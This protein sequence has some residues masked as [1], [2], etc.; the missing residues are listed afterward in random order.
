MGKGFRLFVRVAVTL[1]CAPCAA[2]PPEAAKKITTVRIRS[3]DSCVYLLSRIANRYK[4]DHPEIDVQFRGGGPIIAATDLAHGKADL[5]VLSG[6]KDIRQHLYLKGRK[7]SLLKDVFKEGEVQTHT[8]ARRVMAVVVHPKSP[9]NEISDAT[10][11]GIL[12]SFRSTR[13]PNPLKRQGI[14]YLRDRLGCT[15]EMGRCILGEQRISLSRFPSLHPPQ[16]VYDRVK[17][18]QKLMAFVAAGNRLWAS[19]LKILPVRVQET[20]SLVKLNLQNVLSGKYPYQLWLL[21]AIHPDATPQA[22]QV[23]KELLTREVA[24]SL[25]SVWVTKTA[26]IGPSPAVETVWPAIDPKALPVK[27]RGGVAVLPTRPLSHYFLMSGPAVHAAYEDKVCQGI[28][29]DG[30][31]KLVDRSELAR[32]LAERKLSLLGKDPLPRK[33]L[34]AA[35]VTVLANVITD[36]AA[37]YLRISAFH[38]PTASCIGMMRLPIDPARPEEFPVPLAKKVAQWWPGVLRNL[39]AAGSKPVWT[40]SD[41]SVVTGRADAD[42]DKSC[43]ALQEALAAHKTI[44]FADPA[45]I[46][47]AQ[48]EVLMR[49]MGLAR[50]L[51]ARFTP[52]ADYLLEFQQ[53]TPEEIH[54][55]LLRG[56]DR[57]LLAEKTFREKSSS[58]ALSRAKAWLDSQVAAYPAKPRTAAG[59][60]A[61]VSLAAAK[62]QARVEC[63]RAM[64][65]K[66]QRTELER[67]ID[68][69]PE[70]KPTPEQAARLQRLKRQM[71]RHLTVAC[72]Q[73][74][75]WVEPARELLRCLPMADAGP[76]PRFRENAEMSAQFIHRFPKHKDIDA[77][78]ARVF[79]W[80]AELGRFVE[81]EH[82]RRLPGMGIPSGI[83]HKMEQKRC[84]RLA[85]AWGKEYISRNIDHPDRRSNDL[86]WPFSMFLKIH[87]GRLMWYLRLDNVSEAEAREVVAEWAQAVDGHPEVVEHS[88]FLRLRCYVKKGKKQA[89]LKLLT[90]MQKRWPDPKDAQWK[91]AKEQVLNDL[92]EMFQVD[93]PG[94]SFYQ[95][96]HGK[97]GIG[98]LP[99]VGYK[100]PKESRKE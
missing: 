95:W 64:V 24:E 13:N 74:P 82:L 9:F 73:D 98:D 67:T 72:Q 41:T 51:G 61:E 69:Q 49:M 81:D 53:D 16:R 60:V 57:K 79:F 5:A 78:M 11:R 85:L 52:A 90:A 27:V 68:G 48:R 56:R 38:T 2:A 40:L 50:P 63:E 37:T 94:T 55:R 66:K 46:P 18:D 77:L 84:F 75:T 39:V 32:V 88:D 54:L 35:D 1:L 89:Y 3:T 7:I 47:L 30:Q 23:G 17:N 100:P 31:L 80:Y 29:A 14:H 12:Q 44:F 97:R 34:I 4:R 33:P 58:A 21:L 91:L 22:R 87:R 70:D 93:Q 65:L 25:S 62:K 71:R 59:G 36:R 10:V 92:S 42:A 6:P 86:G 26:S 43:A 45:L 8:I 96:L 19:G 76:Y 99:Y 20:R 15:L 83:D 28:T